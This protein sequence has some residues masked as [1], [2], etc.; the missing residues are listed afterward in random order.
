MFLIGE[1]YSRQTISDRLGGQIQTYLPTVDGKVV[2]GCFK[3]T[4]DKNPGAPEKVTYGT[5]DHSKPAAL[6][7]QGEPIPVFL[8]RAST[9]WEYVG[10]Y[11]CVGHST[12]PELLDAEMRANPARG[13]IS[14]VLYFGRVG[15]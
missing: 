2:C 10:R 3:A 6:V 4:P 14:G 9:E 8:Y 7:A 15:D 12:H 11:L 1:T 13:V 5:P